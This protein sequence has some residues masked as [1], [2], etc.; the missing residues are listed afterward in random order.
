MLSMHRQRIQKDQRVIKKKDRSANKVAEPKSALERLSVYPFRSPAKDGTTLPG[1]YPSP[2]YIHFLQRTI[3][4]Q[5]VDSLFDGKMKIGQ[6]YVKYVQKADPLANAVMRMSELDIQPKAIR[7][8]NMESDGNKERTAESNS[9]FGRGQINANSL[10]AKQLLM[11]EI[12]TGFKS[13][14]K[15]SAEKIAIRRQIVTEMAGEAARRVAGEVTGI[16]VR[17]PGIMA[18]TPK[19]PTAQ[20]LRNIPDPKTGDNVVKTL[21]FNDRIFVEEKGGA[22][23]EWFKITTSKGDRGWVPR[24]SVAL[25]PPE[26]LAELYRVKAG[27]RAIFLAS[28]W[29]GPPGGWSRWWWPGSDDEVDARFYVGA[30]A[31]ANKGRAG[32][33]S[34][35]NLTER[36]AWKKVNVIKGH[37]IW[38]PS[39][40]FLQTL[41]GKVSS[42]SITKELWE[43]VKKVAQ[44]IWDFAVF[45][46]AFISGLIYGAGESIYDLFAG[47]VELVKMV[48]SL[49]KSIITGN[50]VSDAKK[51]WED[52]QKIDISVLARD[53]QKKWF[54]PD[55]WDAG[56]FQGRVLGYVIM[57]IVMLVFSGG[58]LTALKWAGKFAKIGSLIAKLP[59]VAKAVELASKTTKLPS[60]AKNF[61]KASTPGKILTGSMKRVVNFGGRIH[62][63]SI[64]RIGGKLFVWICSTCGPFID[65]LNDIIRRLPAE[66]GPVFQRVRRLRREARKVDRRLNQGKITANEAKQK[67][68]QL[69]DRLEAIGAKFP[70]E[71]AL[72]G[73]RLTYGDNFFTKIRKHAQ[74]M[75][76]IARGYGFVIPKSP[77]NPNTVKAMK[78]FIQHVVR[79]GDTRFGRYMTFPDAQWSRLGDGIVIRRANGEFVTFLDYSL[80]GV[81][82]QWD[83]LP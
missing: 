74:Q 10:N 13:Q 83:R 82:K 70:G 38:K 42:G 12:A 55:P 18:C 11:S 31:F 24:A 63:L 77:A 8:G 60:K 15:V 69:A 20:Y 27:D 49:G 47:V 58:I 32:M 46:A 54:A 7:S 43:D 30:L 16:P 4:N 67:I 9:F 41:M 65:L 14:I 76:R 19:S 34:P 56:F 23:N 80:G 64:R 62:T 79:N 71:R 61:L 48:W 52:L 3:G 57:E 75:R 1:V 72:T 6:P 50:I 44:A 22:K 33:P 29:Y 25:N 81:A 68:D 36:S 66:K 78:N 37:T 28:R 53:F 26:P 5:A 51:F 35:A 39:K 40:S 21:N 2:R 73:V 45:A 17:R 59:R